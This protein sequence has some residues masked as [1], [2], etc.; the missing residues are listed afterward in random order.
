MSNEPT[1]ESHL[2]GIVSLATNNI[3]KK[4][5]QGQEEHGGNLWDKPCLEFMH[6]EILDMI[7]YYYT[8]RSQIFEATAELEY[9]LERFHNGEPDAEMYFRNALNILTKGNAEGKELDD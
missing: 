6:E 9:G 5:R 3:R 7:V 8:I 1:P 2:E 4:Y